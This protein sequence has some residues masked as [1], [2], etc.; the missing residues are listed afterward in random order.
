[1]TLKL[2]NIKEKVMSETRRAVLKGS[3]GTKLSPP[4]WKNQLKERCMERLKQNRSAILQRLRS[5]D[6]NIS[7]EVKRLTSQKNIPPDRQPRRRTRHPVFTLQHE[8][9]G[10]HLDQVKHAEE[11]QEDDHEQ[12]SIEELVE[13]GKL[14]ADDYLE[15]VH[16][17]EE[18]LETE[19][20]EEISD[21]GEQFA[22]EMIDFEEASLAAMLEGMEIGHS[23]QQFYSGHQYE[24][25][26]STI[27]EEADEYYYYPEE[28]MSP[29]G[30]N[31]L[32]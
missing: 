24:I 9:T 19:L 22:Q 2:L 21:K 3:F 16:S 5:P 27:D 14:S 20:C 7:E 11:Q 23:Q 15:L 28:P 12:Y 6:A 13:T 17:L 4:L 8:V 29:N 18:A 26:H 25:A 30:K 31:V 32:S 10:V 1:V